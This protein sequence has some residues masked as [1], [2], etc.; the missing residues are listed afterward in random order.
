MMKRVSKAIGIFGAL[1]LLG[2]H[3]QRPFANGALVDD[4]RLGAF[5]SVEGAHG[6]T[7]RISA[8]AENVSGRNLLVLGSSHDQLNRLTVEMQSDR[9]HWDSRVWDLRLHPP[10]QDHV[11]NGIQTLCDGNAVGRAVPPGKLIR[12]EL[13]VPMSEI[14]DD[15]LPPGTYK[16]TAR[17]EINGQ[18]SS[19]LPAGSV[20]LR[21]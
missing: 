18:T 3:N 13:R 11:T 19:T 12:F 10:C 1:L 4:F 7:L 15:S 6:D 8:T 17:V 2:C 16:V 9:S 14:L 5:A 20:E 21:K